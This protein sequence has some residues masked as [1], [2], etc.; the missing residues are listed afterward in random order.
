ME[1]QH[2]RLEQ[3]TDIGQHASDLEHMQVSWLARYCI[4]V[5]KLLIC[6]TSYQPEFH[7]ERHTLQSPQLTVGFKVHHLI[8]LN[9]MVAVMRNTHVRKG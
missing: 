8:E 9:L 7:F 2:Y 3:H 5:H 6:Y 4:Y 1:H